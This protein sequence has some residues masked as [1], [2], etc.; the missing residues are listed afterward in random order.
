MPG[1]R[2]RGD[3]TRVDQQ[4]LGTLLVAG[5]LV[6]FGLFWA[7]AATRVPVRADLTSISPGFVPFWGGVAL[8]ACAL[9][10]AVVW[11]RRPA[12]PPAPGEEPLFEPTGQVRVLAGLVALGAY[13]ALLESVHFFITTFA[14]SAVGLALAGQPLGWRLLAYALAI[15]G[16]IFGIFVWWLEVPLPGSRFV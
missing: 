14:V 2:P 4:R 5:F 1:D 15:A 10:L 16:L 7:Y 13:I 8:A 11:W 12:Q 3:G 6:L 9:A